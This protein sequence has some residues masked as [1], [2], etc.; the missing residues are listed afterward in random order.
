MNCGNC[1]RE[2]TEDGP[3]CQECGYCDVCGADVHDDG[4]YEECS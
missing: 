2:I 3:V 1:A 4:H